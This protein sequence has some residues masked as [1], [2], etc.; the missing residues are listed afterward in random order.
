MQRPRIVCHGFTSI[1]GRIHPD[2]WTKP[3]IGTRPN[4]VTLTDRHAMVAMHADGVITSMDTVAGAHGIAMGRSLTGAPSERATFFTKRLE[5]PLCIVH[6]PR[7][8]LRLSTNRYEEGQIILIV[9]RDAHADYLEQARLARVSYVF[10]GDDGMD[11]ATAMQAIHAHYGSTLLVLRAD[12][13]TNSAFM[14]A[15]LVDQVSVLVFPGLDATSGERSLFESAVGAG[16]A[17][18]TGK[19][20]LHVS[21]QTLD[22]GIVWLRYLVEH[23]LASQECSR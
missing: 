22:G 6:D 3:A 15:G 23:S 7:A 11:L 4:V 20:L 5:R 8:I 1:D 19:S 13:R 18:A 17:A 2:R 16:P 10:A 21:T 14:A 12:G 9:A